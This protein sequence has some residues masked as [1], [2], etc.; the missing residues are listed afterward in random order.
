MRAVRRRT[1][2]RAD[3]Y[4]QRGRNE[5]RFASD[6]VTEQSNNDLAKDRA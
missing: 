1:K 2:D 5:G 4:K 6:S 3:D